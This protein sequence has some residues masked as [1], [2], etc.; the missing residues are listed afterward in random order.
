MTKSKFC[1]TSSNYWSNWLTITELS[2]GITNHAR[3]FSNLAIWFSNSYAVWS[4]ITVGCRLALPCV[5]IYIYGR[6]R[7]YKLEDES[8][9]IKTLKW[10]PSLFSKQARQMHPVF[11]TYHY[12]SHMLPRVANA[13]GE[14]Q[15]TLK[16]VFPEC[17][18]SGNASHGEAVFLECQKSC[19]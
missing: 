3:R 4:V 11:G 2:P 17:N 5:Y 15:K 14:C 19:T 8:S 6:I 10:V 1:S 9:Q 7:R 12:C 18:T 16:E 13:L